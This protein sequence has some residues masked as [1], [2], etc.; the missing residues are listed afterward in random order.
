MKKIRNMILKDEDEVGKWENKVSDYT[1]Q[2][3]DE[4]L[5]KELI[6]PIQIKKKS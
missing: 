3:V 5:L 4:E 2:D 6:F 1:I